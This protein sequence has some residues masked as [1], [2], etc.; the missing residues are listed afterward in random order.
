[1]KKKRLEYF[2]KEQSF[3]IGQSPNIARMGQIYSYRIIARCDFSSASKFYC[4]KVC[5]GA[6]STRFS[7]QLQILLLKIEELKT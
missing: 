7:Y 3:L 2:L 4:P 1:M 5:V 6:L